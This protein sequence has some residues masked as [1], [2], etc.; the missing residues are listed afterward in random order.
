M[1]GVIGPNGSGKTSLLRLLGGPKAPD[2]GRV[3]IGGADVR[4][5]RSR[6]RARLVALVEQEAHTGLDLTVRQVV[7]LG[8]IP[9]HGRLASL[10]GSDRADECVIEQVLAETET[11]GL[12]DR[13]WAGLSEGE[14]QRV[15]LARAFAQEP[16][17]LL[18]DEPSNHLDLAHQLD[19]LGRVL[20]SGLTTVAV[21]HD[22]ELAAAFCDD[23]VVLNRGEVVR[24]G[25][26]A[27]V[28]TADLVAEVY[29]VDVTVE[30]HPLSG[31]PHVRWNGL[32]AGSLS[33]APS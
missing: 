4:R 2:E 11:G 13:H 17:V 27:E 24:R 20:A 14:R 31:R 7:E 32:L 1:T 15:Q 26:V 3:S 25:P 8:R 9:H 28:L 5:M 19:L 29:G 12:V 21:L 23:L 30:P 10:A 22:L 16:A 18:L 6:H 33:S